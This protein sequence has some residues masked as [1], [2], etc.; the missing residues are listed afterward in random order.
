MSTF[1]GL[2]TAASALAAARRGIDLVGQ[3]VANQTT[4]GYTRQRLE[5]SSVVPPAVSGRFSTG[6]QP[7]QGVSIDGISRLGDAV[8][9]ARVRDTLASSGYW[10]TKAIA[11]LTAEAALAEPTEN[12]IADRLSQ[13][14]AGW[15]DLSNSPDSTAAAA[16]VLTGAEALAAR[17]ADGYRA[18]AGQ[19]SSAR[20]SVDGM[21][22][23]INATAGEVAQLNA[24]IRDAAASGGSLNELVDRRNLLAQTVSRLSGAVGTVEADGTMTLRLDGNALVS[25]DKARVLTV[26]G[27]SS[28][29]AGRPTVLS[30]EGSFAV[31]IASGELGGML[32][33]LAP[34]DQGGV[35]AGLAASHNDLATSLATALNAQHRAGATSG[36]APGGDFFAL[37]AGGPAALGLTVVPQGR[38]DLALAAPG[39]GA[40]DGTNADAMWAISRRPDGPDAL[41]GDVVSRFAVATAA[42]AGR[43]ERAETGAV[44]AAVAQQSV[45][46]VD[47]DEET[48]NL[49]TYQTAYQAAARVLTAVDEALDVLINRTGLV[50]R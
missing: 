1:S 34:A 26:D 29:E 49:L 43:A 15:Q 5:T 32:A 46:G 33:V 3:N 28:I 13:F 44:A 23:Q 37:S 24:S 31:N 9:D 36:G 4:Q 22:A 25:G 45:A 2:G 35:L 30:W 10:S 8:L 11:A 48:L 19:W 39:G 7:G 12:G 42:D 21:V 47:N 38:T 27:P 17:I 18:V 20:G 16:V 6:V 41:W 50:G 14:W 40:L